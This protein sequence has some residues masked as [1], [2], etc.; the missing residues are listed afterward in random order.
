MSG[1]GRG[2]RVVVA[3]ALAAGLTGCTMT[4]HPSQR[5]ATGAVEPARVEWPSRPAP[6]GEPARLRTSVEIPVGDTTGTLWLDTVVEPAG[7][8]WVRFTEVRGAEKGENKP[9]HYYQFRYGSWFGSPPWADKT[10]ENEHARAAF[11]YA[12]MDKANFRQEF[13]LDMPERRPAV[14]LVIHAFSMR[15]LRG[16]AEVIRE[17]NQRGWAVL[18]TASMSFQIRPEGA[19]PSPKGANGREAFHESAAV[20]ER[21]LADY[22]CAGE[23]A[24]EHVQKVY[25]ELRGRPVVVAGFSLGGIMGP[26]LAARLGERVKAAVLVAGGANFPGILAVSP[27][28][29]R[30]PELTPLKDLATTPSRQRAWEREYLERTRIDPYAAAPALRETPVLVIHAARD[31]IVPSRFGDLLWERLGRPERWVYSGGHLGLLLNVGRYAGEIVDWLEKAVGVE[32]SQSP[33]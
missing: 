10:F 5:S 6:A 1:S 15:V 25:P 3:L 27:I 31:S 29:E 28:G 11:M 8:G 2:W 20:A 24:V 30:I 23:A 14:G 19:P 16:E 17:L 21:L 22:A 12:A 32:V 13:R 7:N 4:R 9:G 26:T 18:S 33:N